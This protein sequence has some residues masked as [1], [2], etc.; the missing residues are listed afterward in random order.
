[1]LVSFHITVTSRNG[2]DTEQYSASFTQIKQVYNQRV[3]NSTEKI[4][5]STLTH[6]QPQSTKHG[7]PLAS[8]AVRAAA[9]ASEEE[10]A[11]R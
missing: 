10:E 11:A 5:E 1:M 3:V 7:E 2:R 9:A 4:G 8:L 6:N